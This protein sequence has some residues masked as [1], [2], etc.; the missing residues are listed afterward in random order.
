MLF[1]VLGAGA[2]DP[3]EVLQAPTE[4]VFLQ[5]LGAP[6]TV[7]GVLGAAARPVLL[8]V[9]GAP[10]QHVLG[11]RFRAV[12]C[13]WVPLLFWTALAQGFV[14]LRAG[15]FESFGVIWGP[16]GP[17]FLQMLGAGTP[18]LGMFRAALRPGFL[19]VLRA[20][21]ARVVL[22]VGAVG[23]A[24]ARSTAAVAHVPHV[25]CCGGSKFSKPGF[26]NT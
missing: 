5:M 1:E 21:A 24:G 2:P 26:S 17:S 20:A 9:F 12:P 8:E 25:G 6:S 19:Q 4:G 7:P 10:A 16:G 14:V 23:A 3:G 11:Q 15:A 22:M 13:V 18:V